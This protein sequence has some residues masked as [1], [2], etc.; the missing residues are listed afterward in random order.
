MKLPGAVLLIAGMCVGP[1]LA[2][3][4]K[5]DLRLAVTSQGGAE[6]RSEDGEL[7]RLNADGAFNTDGVYT[8]T[9]VSSL[10][11][12]V[13]EPTSLTLLA[14]ASFAFAASTSLAALWRRRRRR[15]MRQAAGVNPPN[16][17]GLQLDKTP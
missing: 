8:T 11:R 2:D 4:L 17:T 1:L 15:A 3:T 16:A 14:S 9:A 7:V 5:I 13:P 12:P 10:F 6:P